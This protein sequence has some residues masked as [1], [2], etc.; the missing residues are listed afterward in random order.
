[1]EHKAAAVSEDAPPRI[2]LLVVPVAGGPCPLSVGMV[3]CDR[4]GCACHIAAPSLE[5]QEHFAATGR[6]VETVCANCFK[7][8]ELGLD[9]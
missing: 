7:P 9:Q 6:T 4:C 1:M 8:A 5:L 3:Y 2:L